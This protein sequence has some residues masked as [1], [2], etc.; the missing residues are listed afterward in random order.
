MTDHQIVGGDAQVGW[1]SMPS[2]AHRGRNEDAFFAMP[3]RGFY[4][5]FDGMGGHAAAD[6]AARIA[7]D[8]VQDVLVPLAPAVPPEVVADT[9]R[10]ALFTADAGIRAAGDA[11]GDGRGMG[12]SAVVAV[13]RRAA[14]DLWS[15]MVGWAGDSRALV[16]HAGSLR[17]ETLTLDDGVVRL[18]GSSAAQARKVQAVLGDV[19]DPRQLTTKVRDYFLERNVIIQAVGTSLRHVHITEHAL[20]EGD[21]L[22]LSTDG[23]HDNLTDAEISSLLRRAPSPKAAAEQIVHA[24]RA[25]S[26]EPEHPRA[27]PDDVTTIVVRLA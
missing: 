20:G 16:L 22:L 11:R 4:G 6:L 25:R 27:K 5:V 18:H 12:A 13:I 7:A 9:I 14:G 17:L 24:A 10:D 2:E 1:A 23:V 21:Q 3:E 26:L 8:E 19:T 15:A